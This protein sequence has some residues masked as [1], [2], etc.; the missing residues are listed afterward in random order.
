LPAQVIIE[1][2]LDDAA[3]LAKR[4]DIPTPAL[5][6]LGPVSKYRETLDWY[7]P[8]LRENPYG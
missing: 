6:V 4:G 3:T 2:T 8:E 1:A 7:V 5:V